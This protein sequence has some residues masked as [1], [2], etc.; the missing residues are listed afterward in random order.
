M[1]KKTHSLSITEFVSLMATLMA[2][3]ALAIDALL[4]AL[5]EIANT[6]TTEET[7][8]TQLII[9]ILF[10]GLATG[11]LFFGTL[12]DFIGRKPAICLGVSI[13]IIGCLI[14]FCSKNLE[15][16]LIGR[17]FQGIGLSGPRII[18]VALIRDQYEGLAMA[19]IMSFVM[20]IFIIVPAIAPALGQGILF[21]VTWRYIFLMLIIV[22]LAALFWFMIRQPETLP[23]EQRKSFSIMNIA[24]IIS[25]IC[26]NRTSFGYTVVTGLVSGIFLGFLSSIQQIF[27]SYNYSHLFVGCFAILA[28]FIGSASLI[29]AKAVLR[30][31]VRHMVGVALVTLS[32]TSF[33]FLLSNLYYPLNFWSIMTYFMISLFSI[34]I[35]FGNL[36]ALAMEPLGA[37]AGIGSSVVGSLSTFISVP[38]GILIGFSYNGSA[39]PLIIGFFILSSLSLG[40]MYWIE[41]K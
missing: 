21:F 8:N 11:Q 2:L 4:P 22:A 9:S 13:F 31:G 28:L 14:S 5:D 10:L 36:S 20:S 7:N 1:N 38:F 30:Y 32:L 35:L 3:V 40:I 19:R 6:L 27:Q 34:G 25:K 33:I 16:M 41:K 12:S 17:L 26:T 24:N 39:I 23:K 18:S 37:I 29:N 15:Y